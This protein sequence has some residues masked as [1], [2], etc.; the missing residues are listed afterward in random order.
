MF[1]S[2]SLAPDEKSFVVTIAN[3]PPKN[4]LVYKVSFLPQEINET[5]P[6]VQLNDQKLLDPSFKSNDEIMAINYPKQL[7]SWNFLNQKQTN[8]ILP[9]NDVAKTNFIKNTE[10]L[11]VTTQNEVIFLDLK[12]NLE[13]WLKIANRFSDNQV[14]SASI[15]P[16]KNRVL[17]T[18]H[19]HKSPV[20]FWNVN[21][22]NEIWKPLF[23]KGAGGFVASEF[24]SD[25]KAFIAGEKIQ[26]VNIDEKKVLLEFPKESHYQ[27]VYSYDL[28]INKRILAIGSS[29]K[30][31][32]WDLDQGRE[33]SQVTSFSGEVISIAL[34]KDQ[35]H[36]LAMDRYKIEMWDF[37]AKKI[38]QSWQLSDFLNK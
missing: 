23:S 30:V 25:S 3:I 36:F 1:S 15:S 4:P 37:E 17:L 29:G 7:I 9:L 2:F 31:H 19:D 28:A 10:Y 34:L 18:S 21:A 22:K 26:I 12:K 16:S 38:T 33:L 20:T 6:F 27:S 14:Y 5:L 32:I 35:K 11:F 24:L 13:P 8:R